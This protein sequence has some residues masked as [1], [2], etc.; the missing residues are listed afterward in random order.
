MLLVIAQACSIPLTPGL[1]FVS[2]P[3]EGLFFLPMVPLGPEIY[4][5]TSDV[6]GGCRCD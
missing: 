2:V 3:V 6:P 4:Y 1:L 5:Q